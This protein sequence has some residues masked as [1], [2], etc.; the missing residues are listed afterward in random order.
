M[1]VKGLRRGAHLTMSLRVKMLLGV[2]QERPKI[3]GVSQ[4]L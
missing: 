2:L 1:Y 3:K 4:G